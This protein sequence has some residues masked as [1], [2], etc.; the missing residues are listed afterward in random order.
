MFSVNLLCFVKCRRGSV[1]LEV[2]CE[3]LFS[4][5]L[6][7]FVKCHVFSNFKVNQFTDSD[8]ESLCTVFSRKKFLAMCSS[9]TTPIAT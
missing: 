6:K 1:M 7:C 3:M 5:M 8:K 2:F 9:G 4:V